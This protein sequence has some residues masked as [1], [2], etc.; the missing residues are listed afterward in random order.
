MEFKSYYIFSP[1]GGADHIKKQ[2]YMK[3]REGANE[4]INLKLSFSAKS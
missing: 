4:G 2:K 3:L 1:G